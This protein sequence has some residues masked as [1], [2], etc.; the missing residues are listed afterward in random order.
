MSF[1]FSDIGDL[2]ISAVCGSS[3]GSGPAARASSPS[4]AAMLTA[5]ASAATSS[6]TR[7][8]RSPRGARFWARGEKLARISRPSSS[9]LRKRS[10]GSLASILPTIRLNASGTAGLIS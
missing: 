10:S 8:F 4:P 7:C 6:E 5:S 3:V 2:G 9:T 1:F